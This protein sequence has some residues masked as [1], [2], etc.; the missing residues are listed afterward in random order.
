M[1]R[2]L[3]DAFRKGLQPVELEVWASNERAIGLYQ[4]FGFQIEG[5]KRKARFIGG[6][7]ED[8]ITMELLREEVDLVVLGHELLLER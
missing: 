6:Y 7:Y 8:I 3:E 2:A 1:A 5:R 4:K